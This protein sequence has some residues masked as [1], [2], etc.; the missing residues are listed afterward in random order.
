MNNKSL[1]ELNKRDFDKC[2]FCLYCLPM[3]IYMSLDDGKIDTQTIYLFY[4][5]N[6]LGKRK[7]L[8]SIIASNLSSTSSWYDFFQSFKS[9][10][11]EQIIYAVLPN[12][13]SLKDALKLTFLNVQPVLSIF[14]TILKISKYFSASYSSDLLTSVKNVYLACDLTEYELNLASFKESY[15]SPFVLDLVNDNLIKAK[16]IYSLPQHIRKNIFSFYFLRENLKKLIVISHSKQYFSSLDDFLDLC[17]PIFQNFET[18]MYCSKT[19]WLAVLDYLYD[20]KKDLIKPY[21]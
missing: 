13:K 2:L 17:L 16:E 11:L 6:L 18:K 14:D 5:C 3:D 19:D 10:G 8:S 20:F 9:R 21:L 15:N 4:G 12:N 7:Y 1:I